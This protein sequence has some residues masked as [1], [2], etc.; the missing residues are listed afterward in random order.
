MSTDDEIQDDPFATP[1]DPKT[2]ETAI[3]LSKDAGLPY[4]LSEGHKKIIEANWKRPLKELVQQVWADPTITLMD[5]RAKLVKQHLATLGKEPTVRNKGGKPVPYTLSETE[6][7]YIETNAKVAKPYEMAQHL[8]GEGIGTGSKECR[9][10]YAYYKQIDPASIRDEELVED[11][12]YEPPAHAMIVLSLVNKYTLSTRHDGKKLLDPAKLTAHETRQLQCLLTYMRS[13]L[14]KVAADRYT[15][16]VDRLLLES[17]IV[18]F[19]WDK[20]DLMAE[21][22]HQYINLASETVKYNQIERMVQKLDQRINDMLD[23]AETPLKMAE[24]ELLNSVREKANVSMKQQA[25]FLKTLVGERSKREE[26][27]SK[28]NSDLHNLVAS[29]MDREKRRRILKV[30]NEYRE[31]LGEEVQRLSDMDSLRADL[32]GLD[33]GDI[34]K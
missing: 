17:T 9:A 12:D 26:E 16:K 25:A 13:P 5:V 27:R 6:R 22:V 19:C 15:R 28:T 31:K 10:V 30:A 29:F 23:D 7:L 11:T 2:L 32:F 8:F 1:E 4:E 34:L 18:S 14:F 33:S 3:T 20:T 24:V 21:E